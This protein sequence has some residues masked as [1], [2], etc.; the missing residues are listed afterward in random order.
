MEME[1]ESEKL[2]VYVCQREKE[3]IPIQPE[4]SAVTEGLFEALSRGS[5][6]S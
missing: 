4:T 6:G 5:Y 3:I 1:K 2:F